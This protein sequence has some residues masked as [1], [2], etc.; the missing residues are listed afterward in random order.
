MLEIR[1]HS[2]AGQGA[3]TGAKGLADVVAGKGKQ[4]QA[5]AFYGSAKRGTAMTAYNRVDE[6]P[7]LNHEKFMQPDYV[8]VIDPG[9][10]FIVDICAHEKPDTKY[11]IT[12]H[13]SKEEL[14]QKKP[15]LQG[16]QVYTLDCI[17]ISLDTIGKPIPNAPMLGAL[18]KVSKILELDYFLE[19]FIK[20]L[21]KKLPQKIIDANKEAIVRAY[22]EV[23]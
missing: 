21:G 10:P 7:I 19:A 6:S 20:L 22:N 8:L 12:T 16:K 1:W 23:K 17:K 5:F 2:R 9:L 15:E 4:V 13:L 18:M 14:L 11:I 3:V